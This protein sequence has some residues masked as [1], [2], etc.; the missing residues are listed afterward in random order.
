MQ[1]RQTGGRRRAGA[2]IRA[3]QHSVRD[4]RTASLLDAAFQ[5][6]IGDSVFVHTG[7]GG[8]DPKVYNKE[9]MVPMATGAWAQPLPYRVLAR[10]SGVFG[11]SITLQSGTNPPVRFK[12]S[13]I[14]STLQKAVRRQDFELADKGLTLYSE[15]LGDDPRPADI[16]WL[17]NRLVIIA[18]EDAAHSA[19]GIQHAIDLWRRGTDLPWP[20][21]E[22]EARR[23]LFFLCTHG[24]SR[25]HSWMRAFYRKNPPASP[26]PHRVRDIVNAIQRRL[27]PGGNQDEA[28]AFVDGIQSNPDAK[29]FRAVMLAQAK[30]SADPMRRIFLERLHEFV[31][32]RTLIDTKTKTQNND[33]NF[34]HRTLVYYL[35]GEIADLGEGLSTPP[36]RR[37]D[38]MAEPLPD[39]AVNDIHVNPH[40]KK[41]KGGHKRFAEVGSFIVN[42]MVQQHHLLYAQSYFEQKGV[43]GEALVELMRGLGGDGPALTESEDSDGIHIMG[44]DSDDS[45]EGIPIMVDDSDDS[46]DSDIVLPR[47]RKRLRRV[48]DD[49][50]DDDDDTLVLSPSQ[51][52][53][54]A[55]RHYVAGMV[56]TLKAPTFV[57]GDLFVKLV[58]QTAIQEA[59]Y[60][61]NCFRSLRMAGLSAPADVRVRPC[62]AHPAF[63]EKLASTTPDD[64]R[65]DAQVTSWTKRFKQCLAVTM[66]TVQDP[67]KSNDWFR[68][69]GVDPYIP[70][71]ARIL[72]HRRLVQTSDNN[73]SNVMYEPRSGRLYSVDFNYSPKSNA[74]FLMGGFT[75]EILS[76]VNVYINTHRHEMNV[77]IDHVQSQG[78]DFV[79]MAFAI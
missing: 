52:R 10:S 46:D 58:P 5:E 7:F 16:T 61:A 29:A 47:S 66:A 69:K 73:G 57:H 17:R 63:F 3:K 24:T 23:V 34:L 75:K 11:G 59:D 78:F 77:F 79:D 21:L 1:R 15:L 49:E 71:L 2:V 25:L 54:N 27:N 4:A 64:T 41:T 19:G 12:K 28:P 51:L 45:D 44:D 53:M 22:A 33:S 30:R 8:L 39:F 36:L 35:Y 14:K 48:I 72:V 50:E 13:A 67:V 65:R 76:K 37:Y 18:A 55:S 60:I 62:I 40:A 20:I 70:E 68:R 42:P 26:M 6:A 74:G 43:E 56:G 32:T 38:T 9:S 31:K